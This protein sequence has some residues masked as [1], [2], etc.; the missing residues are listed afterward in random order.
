MSYFF[1]LILLFY[2]PLANADGIDENDWPYQNCNP[3]NIKYTKSIIDELSN[4]NTEASAPCFECS[5]NDYLEKQKKEVK[6][7]KKLFRPI[8]PKECFL[9]MATRGNQVFE[10][11]QYKHC[12]NKE[13][14]NE[15][16]IKKLCANKEYIDMIQKSFN[17]MSQCFNLNAR[18]QGEVFALINQESGGILN[19][20]SESGARCL[21]Q[22]TGDYV[23]T[24]NNI[25]QSGNSDIYNKT[26]KRCPEVENFQ[27]GNTELEQDDDHLTCRV[28]RD[29]YSC[30]FYTFF[31]LER[32]HQ[33]IKENLNSSG[34]YIG[35]NKELLND[36]GEIKEFTKEQKEKFDLPIKTNEM[37]TFNI[38]FTDSNEVA[39]YTFWDD[40][41]LYDTLETV[42][43][44]Q[45]VIEDITKIRKT[46][47]FKENKKIETMFYYW[48]HNGG[49]HYAQKGLLDMVER[50]KKSIAQSCEPTNSSERCKLRKQI[51]NGKALSAQQVLPFFE[52]DLQRYY[53]ADTKKRRSEV[54]EYV[55]NIE[56]N[57]QSTFG[58]I[59]RT[60]ETNMML[61]HYIK[62]FKFKDTKKLS[63]EQATNF[64]EQVAEKC[65]LEEF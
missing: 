16:S 17:N 56:K 46:P 18:K 15:P 45:R 50:L 25:I 57:R 63:K 32:S 62:S 24:L 5:Y 37:L 7:L 58:Y 48:S 12:P 64:Q 43:E 35:G 13:S 26:L 60:K 38:K 65:Q 22:V 41:E 40:L 44:K 4:D 42:R 1:T 36:E 11:E 55:K 47:V 54:A 61:N 52:K 33:Q 31:G 27:I 6:S 2:A 23:K 49:T 39:T 9:A 51:Q 20:L 8:I 28:T 21:G 59:A 29:P 10:D 30:L 14:K 3:N 53:P 34:R 19:I